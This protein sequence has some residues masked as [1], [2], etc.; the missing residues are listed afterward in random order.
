[1]R[2]VGL[3]VL[4]LG[5]VLH[6]ATPALAQFGTAAEPGEWLEMDGARLRVVLGSAAPDGTVEGAI[7][8]DLE[9]GWKTYW[10]APGPVG[11][12]PSFDASASTNL[13]LMSIEHPAPQAFQEF[14]ELS[15]GY[16]D[17]VAFA[18]RFAMPDPNAPAR[19]R[20]NGFF[21]ICAEICVPVPLRVEGDVVV[22][23]STPF[24][25]GAAIRAARESL[26]VEGHPAL[27]SA[28]VDGDAVVI[29][30]AALDPAT[31]A[32]VAPSTGLWLGLAERVGATLRAPIRSGEPVGTLEVV[33]RDGDGAMRYAVPI[34]AD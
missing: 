21:G 10:I 33:I 7:E 19:L 11:I 28:R 34:S 23:Q 18:L 29:E 31:D 13:T 24:E 25:T 1:M 4:A 30:G 2:I 6:L 26:P 8:I 32:F 12:P 17:D 9:P 14:G 22:G 27:L 3:A 20:A 5:F 16:K 15:V